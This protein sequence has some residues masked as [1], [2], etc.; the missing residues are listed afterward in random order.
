MQHTLG[1]QARGFDVHFVVEQGECLQGSGAHG[2]ADHAEFTCRRVEDGHRGWRHG[3][4]P[5]AVDA[6]T[7]EVGA[8]GALE[9]LAPLECRELFPESVGLIRLHG[10]TAHLF[11]EQAGDGERLIADHLGRQAYART[12]RQQAIF[13]VALAQR[14]GGLRL[15][16]VGGGRHDEALHRLD[17]PAGADEFGGEPVEQFGMARR[18]ALGSKILGGL[19]QAGAEVGLPVAVHR[20]AR[21]E[22]MVRIGEP[23]REAEAVGRGARGQRREE[24]GYAGGDL[25]AGFL[26]AA[27]EEDKGVARRCHFLHDHRGGNLV[28]DGALLG[29]QFGDLFVGAAA[30]PGMR[31]PATRSASR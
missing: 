14:R 24:R 21:G 5:E 25:F 15:L 28:F 2:P 7:P 20:Y 4:L 23:L 27:A 30:L 16:P 3:A 12:A 1:K 18:F 26:I 31:E 17:V 6:A 8:L 29:L 11:V 10:R 13:G 19:H 22:G 9:E